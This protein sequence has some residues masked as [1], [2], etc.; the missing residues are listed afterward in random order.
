M[1]QQL[2]DRIVKARQYAVDEA[3]D[4]RLKIQQTVPLVNEDRIRYEARAA[5]YTAVHV[6]LGIILGD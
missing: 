6:A 4:A 2:E 5:A 1:D 3:T